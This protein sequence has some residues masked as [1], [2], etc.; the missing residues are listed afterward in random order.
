MERMMSIETKTPRQSQG[1]QRMKATMTVQFA[2]AIAKAETNRCDELAIWG[3]GHVSLY[4][5][6]GR[7]YVQARLNGGVGIAYHLRK[8]GE[9]WCVYD[10]DY[11]VFF[12]IVQN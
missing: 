5:H 6:H 11:E 8:E 10:L 4:P 9:T 7:H 1:D 3:D 12:P 2:N